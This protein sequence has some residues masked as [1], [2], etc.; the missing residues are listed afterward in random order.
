MPDV[1]DT[2][3]RKMG[4]IVELPT[5][6]WPETPIAKLPGVRPAQAQR[7]LRLGIATVS[8]LLLHLP[9]RYEDTRDLVPLAGLRPGQ[10]QTS[11]V[12]VRE[13][14]G[15]RSPQRRM[16]LVEATL[17]DGGSQVGAI[18]FNQPYLATQLRPGMEI[19]V[20]GKVVSGLHGLTFQNPR[21]ERVSTDP[22]HVGRLAAV[23]PE[24]EGVTSKYLRALI[25]RILPVTELMPDR[26]P[27]E[28]REAE[29]LMPM[30]EALRQV[31][32]PDDANLASA[33]R[34][35]LAFEELFL[36]QMAADRARRRRLSSTGV[37][38]PYDVDV[39]RAFSAGLPFRLTD[40]Q[41]RAAHQLLTDLA[42]PGPMNRL[43][44]GDVG[45][46]KT[47]VAAMAA[48]MTCRAGFQCVVMAPTEILARQHFVTLEALLAPHGLAPRLLLGSTGARARREIL[49][50]LAAGH[51]PLVVGTH[52]LIEDDVVLNDLGLVVVDEQHRFGVAQR[53]RLRLK[54]RAMPNFLAM[55]ATPIPRSLALTVYGDVDV[56]ELREMPPGRL[57]VET[58]V[59]PPAERQEAY[60][61]VRGQVS[62][63]RQVFVICPLI[64]ES[65]KLGVRSVTAE[66]RK[67]EQEVFPDL[68]LEMLH[69]RMP[70][71]EKAERMGRFAA[72]EADV[73]VATSVV[74]VGVDVP[75]ASVMI[76][77]G[78]ER[79]GLAQLH[80]LRGRVGRDRHH[81]YCLLFEEAVD[82]EGSERLRAVAA[83]QSG[84]DL[85]ELD[86]RLRGPGD[87]AGLRQ[88]GL[89][90]MRAADLLD[91]ALAVRARTA[92]A[93]WLEHDPEVTA[94][95]P[96]RE[97]MH[98]YAAVF[99]LD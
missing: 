55:T 41:R 3:G 29:G 76:V 97:A 35:R 58:R 34:E 5:A 77:E 16:P 49:E 78:A 40:G 19:L 95:E 84:F 98:G 18:W 73:L 2:Q 45:S 17:E 71:R 47:A 28:V 57:P 9:R 1:A 21:F 59:V 6:C 50:G 4:R 96:L 85:A 92:A 72:G 82:E 88:H 20:S 83:T 60:D 33:A 25:R 37:V 13:V 27:S 44:Q 81:A 39:A 86:L 75:N 61:F 32:L 7:L 69:G 94:Y 22:Q 10:V 11:R 74:E 46:G 66:H 51:D 89:P 24:T 99:D 63:G 68:R 26:L 54:A 31:H 8:D 14:S 64:E 67:L 52:A 12:R 38:V 93:A 15:H 79:F 56:I 42:E 90:E 30:G 65:D 70:S 62:A 53:Q 91:V 80:Q 23:Y 36:I 48:L 87:V 43:L